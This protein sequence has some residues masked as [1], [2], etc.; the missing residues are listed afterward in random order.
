MSYNYPK[1][2]DIRAQ[3]QLLKAY[4]QKKNSIDYEISS[5]KIT[6]NYRQ[7]NSEY[8]DFKDLGALTKILNKKLNELRTLRNQISALEIN[9]FSTQ[10]VDNI[11]ETDLLGKKEF[12][13]SLAEANSRA[14][15]S[16]LPLKQNLS[17]LRSIV[18]QKALIYNV[19]DFKIRQNQ[20]KID[21]LQELNKDVR[22]FYSNIKRFH[23]A[24][25]K[26]I[27]VIKRNSG[28]TRKNVKKTTNYESLAEKAA[29]L[30]SKIKRYET[31]RS[32]RY[33]EVE[34]LSKSLETDE[35]NKEFDLILYKRD[36]D[37]SIKKELE[38]S[39]KKDSESTLNLNIY[40]KKPPLY[41]Y[42]SLGEADNLSFSAE[43]SEIKEK[44]H[45][46]FVENDKLKNN[47]LKRFD[48]E[49]SGEK[50]IL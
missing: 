31:N 47:F 39:I 46:A 19:N 40:K 9:E 41:H 44:N 2:S 10:A 18:D 8:K 45:D 16:L 25:S 24:N 21:K 4:F 43:L 23:E 20:V 17:D 35:I 14:E 28:R 37:S 7:S 5:L 38:D 49:N 6:K 33:S 34:D 29:K 36:S 3:I 32:K 11:P 12:M 42:Q 30:R 15:K 50:K 48:S 26:I 22:E 13:D 1:D 27:Q